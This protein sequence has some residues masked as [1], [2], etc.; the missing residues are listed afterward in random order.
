LSRRSFLRGLAAGAASAV[1]LIPAAM[2]PAFDKFTV[3]GNVTAY[4]DGSNR[5][6]LRFVQEDCFGVRPSE[7]DVKQLWVN[8][9]ARLRS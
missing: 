4:F 2:C 8:G 7:V 5:V 6:Q 9:Y 1:L 3:T